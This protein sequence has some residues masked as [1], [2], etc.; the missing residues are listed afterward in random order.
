MKILLAILANVFCLSVAA[1]QTTVEDANPK[2][3]A[4]NGSFNSISLSDGVSLFLTAGTEETL[5]VRFSEEKYEERFK[6]EVSGGVLKIYYDNKGLN[7]TDNKRRKLTAYVSFKNLEKI[8][9]SGGASVKLASPISVSNLEMKFASGSVS[10]GTVKGKEISIDQNCGSVVTMSGSAEKIILVATSG[11]IFEGYEFTGT[12]CEAKQAVA[13][14][15]V[16]RLTKNC[17][18]VRVAEEA[19]VTKELLL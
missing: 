11:A 1:R 17:L 7:Y 8:V 19:F 10:E 9:G 14:K 2:V 13:V 12:F 18:P 5:A 4:L 6:S 3:R 15:Y 16:F